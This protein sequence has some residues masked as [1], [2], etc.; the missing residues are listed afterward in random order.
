MPL[1]QHS[2]G[3]HGEREACL[4]RRPAPMQHLFETTIRLKA[5]AR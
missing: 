5:R 1:D 2:E 3:G 4:K